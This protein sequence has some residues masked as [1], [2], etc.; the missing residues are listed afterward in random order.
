M[1]KNDEHVLDAEQLQSLRAAWQPEGALPTGYA[2]RI[3]RTSQRRRRQRA[4]AT[5]LL[6]LVA[7]S[8][9]GLRLSAPSE[10]RALQVA[11]VTPVV[12][13]ASGGASQQA[14]FVEE[15]AAASEHVDEVA[16]AVALTTDRVA[17]SRHDYR[18][19]FRSMGDEYDG[20]AAIYFD[21][22]L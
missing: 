12:A 16:E 1:R 9:A 4:G 17:P 13:E 21:D 22:E 8:Y 3:V 6:L 14:G 15:P 19:S 10:D 2:E 20:L 18:D 11:T 7:V 5:A